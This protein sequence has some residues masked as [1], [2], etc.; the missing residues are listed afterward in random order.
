MPTI[1][2][3]STA[4]KAFT[5]DALRDEDERYTDFRAWKSHGVI[6]RNLRETPFYEATPMQPDVVLADLIKS[7]SSGTGR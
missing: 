6:Y 3:Y 7:L 2:G 4:S 1:G 5:Y